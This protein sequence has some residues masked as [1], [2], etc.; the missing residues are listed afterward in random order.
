L[1]VLCGNSIDANRLDA[2]SIGE[3]GW[4]NPMDYRPTRILDVRAGA[5]CAWP[6]WSSLFYKSSSSRSSLSWSEVASSYYALKPGS[7]LLRWDPL[8]A[9]A[10]CDMSPSILRSFLRCDRLPAC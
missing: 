9:V 7:T 6:W 8:P 5:S 10:S 4:S 1:V 2:Y 3:S